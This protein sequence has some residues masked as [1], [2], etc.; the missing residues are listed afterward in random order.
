MNIDTV[1]FYTNS[2]S[3]ITKFYRDI[4]GFNLEYQDGDR[5]VSFVFPN[6]VKLGIKKKE[7]ERELPGTQTVIIS[8]KS[9]IEDCYESL[10]QKNIPIY[11]ELAT[12][13]WGKNFSVLDPD[14]NKVEFVE[15]PVKLQ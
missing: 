15:R 4:L 11:K 2:I 12:Q 8:T 14:K 13:E 7:K 6:G 1:V 9:G 5:Y 10:Q 3:K